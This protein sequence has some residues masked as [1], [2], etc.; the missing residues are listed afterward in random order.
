M[1]ATLYDVLGITP[2]ATAALIRAAYRTR[3]REAH[4]D[5]GGS[6][7]DAVDVN[8]AYAVLGDPDARAAYDA[9]LTNQRLI[10]QPVQTHHMPAQSHRPAAPQQDPSP[11]RYP[12][13]DLEPNILRSRTWLTAVLITSFATTLVV[14]WE[15]FST[16]SA[17]APDGALGV[18]GVTSAALLILAATAMA[19]T[20]G[21][22]ATLGALASTAAV[23]V[24]SAFPGGIGPVYIVLVIMGFGV[25]LRVMS[26]RQRTMHAVAKVDAFHDACAHPRITGWFVERALGQGPVSMLS[27]IDVNNPSGG[28]RNAQVWGSYAPG[29]LVAADLNTAPGRVVVAVTETEL[30]RY[31]KISVKRSRRQS[32]A[33]HV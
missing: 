24:I 13:Y 3:I 30:S 23:G 17:F 8:R 14:G 16:L 22:G 5:N 12:T 1:S 11:V 27:L 19:I 31:E 25:L 21:R 7:A 10:P 28:E 18:A 15:A 32:A 9:T 6:E 29:G 33:A 4:P 20:I 26:A 2:T